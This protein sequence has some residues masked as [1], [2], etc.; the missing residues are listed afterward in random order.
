MCRPVVLDTLEAAYQDAGNRG[1]VATV[2]RAR[3]DYADGDD[4][5]QM[6]ENLAAACEDGGGTPS[7]AIDA[8]GRLLAVD[9]QSDRARDRIVALGRQHGLVARTRPS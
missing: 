8:W 3:L 4:Q 7:E 5:A 6:L 9:S 1:G 2:L